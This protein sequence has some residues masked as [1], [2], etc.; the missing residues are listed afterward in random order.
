MLWILYSFGFNIC[1]LIFINK[2]TSALLDGNSKLYNRWCWIRTL[3]FTAGEYFLQK[4]LQ[5]KSS[6]VF[7][8]SI[9]YLTVGNELS[10]YI[11][12]WQIWYNYSA[13]TY[14]KEVWR[15]VHSRRYLIITLP[16]AVR[17]IQGDTLSSGYHRKSGS[18][19]ELP[20]DHA[21][22]GS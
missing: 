13:T 9:H 8:I 11:L 19:K 17:F 12:H 4:A 7:I 14:Q 3:K 1:T 21:T 15:E 16:L 18:S 6:T 20:Y 22:I 5:L 2:I 10:I